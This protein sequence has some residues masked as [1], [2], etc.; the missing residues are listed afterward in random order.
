[1]SLDT[2]LDYPG[3]NSENWSQDEFSLLTQYIEKGGFVLV[4]NSG[5]NIA[6]V[7]RVEDINEDATDFNSWLKPLGI[8]FKYGETDGGMIR[9]TVEYPL[10]ANA[11]YLTNQQEKLQVFFTQTGGVQL[12][13]GAIGLV[14]Y[15]SQGGQVLV[16]SDLGLLKNNEDGTK[17]LNFVKN[18]AQY[19]RLR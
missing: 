18:I 16:V 9:L 13:P 5:Y 4:T 1:M 8:Q 2:A 14:D 10:S 6:Q 11:K 7:R 15:G 17:N 3:P 12:V 19:V